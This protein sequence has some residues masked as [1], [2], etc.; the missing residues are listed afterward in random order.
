MS[1]EREAHKAELIKAHDEKTLISFALP[2]WGSDRLSITPDMY[3]QGVDAWKAMHPA[4]REQVMG[5][6]R[7]SVKRLHRRVTSGRASRQETDAF[8]ADAALWLT[9]DIL[10]ADGERYLV[11]GLEREQ[12]VNG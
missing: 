4:K 7:R 1:D 8:A 10:F 3:Q 2:G 9:H 6:V 11:K 5:S 12:L